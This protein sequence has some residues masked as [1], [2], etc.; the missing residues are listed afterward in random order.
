MDAE[1][2][3]MH[4][5][6]HPSHI[7]TADK[8]HYYCSTASVHLS[9]SLSRTKDNFWI[10]ISFNYD[11]QRTNDIFLSQQISISISINQI[12]A[13]R[14][15]LSQ[16]SISYFGEIKHG[17]HKSIKKIKIK[18]ILQRKLI[19]HPLSEMMMS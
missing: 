13:K 1:S 16:I 3:S 12:S 14:T 6:E 19:S 11:F 5:I 15:G 4:Q 17:M 7:F 2:R 9:F 18:N 10:Y 8:C